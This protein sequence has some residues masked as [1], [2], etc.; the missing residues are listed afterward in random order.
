[1]QPPPLLTQ[2]EARVEA[3]VRTERGLRCAMDGQCE[4][5]GSY[6][7]DPE[8]NEHVRA[9][10]ADDRRF[11]ATSIWVTTSRHWVTVQGCVRRDAERKAVVALVA[12]SPGVER[13]F[14]ELSVGSRKP[15]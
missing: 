9:L 1:M 2:Q 7:R 4:P 8:I 15:R 3:H 12:K 5:G 10:I 11:A 14:D 13:V 6:R